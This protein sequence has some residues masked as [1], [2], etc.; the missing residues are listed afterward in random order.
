MS[1]QIIRLRDVM[2]KEVLRHRRNGI[3]QGRRGN[4][5]HLKSVRNVNGL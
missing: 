3:C 5:V 2:Q 4:D 1:A